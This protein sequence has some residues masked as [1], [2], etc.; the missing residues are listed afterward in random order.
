MQS[1]LPLDEQMSFA[2]NQSSD[3]LTSLDRVRVVGCV[4]CVSLCVLSSIY[5]C[6]CLFVSF[7]TNQL[8]DSLTSLDRVRVVGCVA[9]VSL[10]VLSSIY[11]C[12]CLFVSF[13]TNQSADSLTS[14]D[15]VRVVGCVACVSLCVLSS[16]SVC[17]LLCISLYSTVRPDLYSVW[18]T[19]LPFCRG[20]L[21]HYELRRRRPRR[22][23]A[24]YSITCSGARSIILLKHFLLSTTYATHCTSW[25]TVYDRRYN[26]LCVVLVLDRQLVAF[27]PY[28]ELVGSDDPLEPGMLSV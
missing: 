1:D 14:L 26:H 27:F 15:R 22:V 4:A 7:A 9:C 16:M 19:V 24:G 13:A 11:V 6:L 10:C 12:L 5:V 20:M 2:T 3:S 28:A 25:S 21:L 8:A 23:S 17:V 18:P